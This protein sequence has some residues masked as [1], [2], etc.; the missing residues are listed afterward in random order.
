MLPCCELPW[1]HATCM[2]LFIGSLKKNLRE[3]PNE[4]YAQYNWLKFLIWVPLF[5]FITFVSEFWI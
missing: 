5:Q 2:V 4:P 3:F 1:N